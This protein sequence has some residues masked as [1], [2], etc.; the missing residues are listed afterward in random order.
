MSHLKFC[1]SLMV[2]S[3]HCFSSL[4]PSPRAAR[5]QRVGA[6]GVLQLRPQ[7]DLQVHQYR[8]AGSPGRRLHEQ[9]VLPRHLHG[10]HLLPGTL[11]G[12]RTIFF[13]KYS[14]AL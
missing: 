4:G 11:V 6:A 7:E 2:S 13:E 8:A 10:A 9:H 5:L 12:V 1:L 3:F 14:S